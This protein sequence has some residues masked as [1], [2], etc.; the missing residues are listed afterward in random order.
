[1]ITAADARRRSVWRMAWGVAAVLSAGIVVVACDGSPSS[2]SS[3][4]TGHSAQGSVSPTPVDVAVTGPEPV[5][6]PT[7]NNTLYGTDFDLSKVGYESSQFFLSGTAHSYAPVSPLASNGQWKIT[8]GVRASYKTRI[9]VYRPI[10]PNKF[11]GTVVVEWLNVSG[12]VDDAP[13]WTLSHNQLIRDGFAWVGVSSQQVGV[14]S[15]KTTD[16]AE[17]SSLSHPGDSFSYDIF[18]QAGQ[19][20]RQ[21]A[22]RILAG[23]RPHSLIAAGESQSAGR[24]MTYIDAVQPIT[25]VYQ[26]F[27]VHSQ[28]GTG[29]PLSQAPQ[30]N[31]SA[32]NPT[33]IRSDI[34]VPGVRV[35]NRNRRLQQQPDRP[36]A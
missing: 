22:T 6:S 20:V 31:Y 5:G 10:N 1:M 19:T 35:R 23:L 15:A 28:F 7:F 26:G 27:L 12:G 34:G 2:V 33:T 17:Y 21:D 11:N 14:D 30:T 18:S 3:A 24:L 36:A 8:T 29:A 13:E 32:P 4:T 16:P 9:A 25:H